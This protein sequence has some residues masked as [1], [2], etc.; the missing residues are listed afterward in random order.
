M[1]P[2]N[3]RDQNRAEETAQRVEALASEPEEVSS[4][5]LHLHAWLGTHALV[6]HPQYENDAGVVIA[7]QASIR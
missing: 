5:S 7:T 4:T 2:Q 6:P 1:K 3:T